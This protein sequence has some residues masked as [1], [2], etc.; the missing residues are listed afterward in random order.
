MLVVGGCFDLVHEVVEDGVRYEDACAGG[1]PVGFSN[2][3][4]SM[5]RDPSRRVT[6]VQLSIRKV[7]GSDQC[8]D[9]G[10]TSRTEEAARLLMVR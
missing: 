10:R 9:R 3:R 5:V 8:G 4:G 1:A 2:L 7:G 6:Q